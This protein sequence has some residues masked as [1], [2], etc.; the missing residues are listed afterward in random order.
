MNKKAVTFRIDPQIIKKLKFLA[1]EQ[2]K[3]LTD[4]LLEAIQLLFKKYKV[5]N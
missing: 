5:K 2:E 3:T 1:V 4:L